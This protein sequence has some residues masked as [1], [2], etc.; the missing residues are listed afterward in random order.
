MIMSAAELK[1]FITTDKT[2]SELEGLLQ[3]LELMI[4]SYTN[5]NFQQRT[6]RIVCNIRNGVIDG[7]TQLFK[8]GDTVEVS[9]SAYNNGIYTINH[10]DT[11]NVCMSLND[12]LIDELQITLT[13]IKYPADVK[14]GVVNLI[15]WDIDKRSKVGVQSETLSRHS[16][17]YFN[18]DGDNSVMGYPKS[19]LGFLKPYIKA[20]F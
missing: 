17:T 6:Y 12:P 7:I 3:A 5:N 15:K 18:M 14:M 19:L 1:Q 2:D 13:K 16:V 10:I 20:R 9:N 4:R 11:E 8:T